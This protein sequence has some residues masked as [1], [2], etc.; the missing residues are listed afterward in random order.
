[1]CVLQQPTAYPASPFRDST[2]LSVS[3]KQGQCRPSTP[4]N[5]P[6]SQD[7]CSLLRLAQASTFKHSS[8]TPTKGYSKMASSTNSEHPVFRQLTVI[9][10]PVNVWPDPESWEFEFCPARVQSGQRCKRNPRKLEQGRELRDQVRKMDKWPDNEELL[11][12]VRDFL[13]KSHCTQHA[14]FALQSLERWITSRAVMSTPSHEGQ[15]SVDESRTSSDS[16]SKS[17]VAE[18]LTPPSSVAAEAQ[19]QAS[20]SVEPDKPEATSPTHQNDALSSVTTGIAA[21]DIN[22]AGAHANPATPS[23]EQI[24]ARGLVKLERRTSLRNTAPVFNEIFKYLTKPQQQE[25]VVYVGKSLEHEDLFIIG[26]TSQPIHK[27]I[28]SKHCRIMNSEIIYATSGGAFFAA[29]K[30]VKLAQ[31]VLSHHNFTVKQC[32]RCGSN[33]RNLFRAPERTVLETVEI[34]ENFV[35]LPAYELDGETW[36]LSGAAHDKIKSMCEFSPASL[37]TTIEE[38]QQQPNHGKDASELDEE[39]S[40]A[41]ISILSE[42]QESVRSWVSDTTETHNS[43]AEDRRGSGA[44]FAKRLRQGYKGLKSR[45]SDAWNEAW[46]GN[47]SQNIG[48][49]KEDAVT[50]VFMSLMPEEATVEDGTKDERAEFSWLTRKAQGVARWLTDFEDEMKRKSEDNENVRVQEHEIAV[51]G[52]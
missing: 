37:K 34:M 18:G 21:I 49:E 6:K 17:T 32:E 28:R 43:T 45:V 13:D 3:P 30:A 8:S 10:E 48:M 5:T 46:K 7:G 39:E 35:R 20:V 38:A 50:G 41:D 36:K 14:K 33:H 1:M 2:S 47:R 15:T 52:Y 12:Q 26:S 27:L 25:G 4:S 22:E 29:A 23:A 51:K 19:P 40:I 31:T 9:L 16:I 11:D 24:I 42:S 44:A